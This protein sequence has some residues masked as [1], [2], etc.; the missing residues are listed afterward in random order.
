MS[1]S[2]YTP[3]TGLTA[4]WERVV[5]TIYD[6]F[7]ALGERRGMARR[8]AA[9]LSRARGTVLEI[10]AG[11]GL[12]VAHYPDSVSRVVLTEPV[13][14]M[15]RRLRARVAGRAGFEVAE[16]PA[17]DLPVESASVDT[18]VSTLVLCTVAD[19]DA[20]LAEV[21]RV[22]KPDGAL[23]FNEH[24]HASGTPLGRWQR[25]LAG[26]WAAFAAGCRCDRDLL[27]HIEEHLDV[28]EVSGGAWSG[29]PPLV[30]PLVTG[31]AAVPA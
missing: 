12:N 25:R 6:P 14:P 20:A 11:T 16:A 19:V 21:A 18:V 1:T 10:G 24:V 13:P 8:R 23:L 26:P 22:L 17:D 15:A 29:M 9:L 28:R 4:V 30:R 31:V 7:L 2:T 3:S 27:A 5:A